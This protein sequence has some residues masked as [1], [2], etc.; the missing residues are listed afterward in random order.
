[1]TMIEV[2]KREM[3]KSLKESYKNTSKSWSKM[4]KTVQDLNLE[5]KS[6]KKTQSGNEIFRNSNRN[7]RG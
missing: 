3:N 1:M 5:I 7:H 4:N 2:L 6:I